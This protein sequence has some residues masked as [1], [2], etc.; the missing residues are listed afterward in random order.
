M[1]LNGY[2]EYLNA[3]IN[4]VDG[5]L[6]V[7]FMGQVETRRKALT[8]AAKLKEAYCSGLWRAPRK[9]VTEVKRRVKIA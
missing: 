8:R 3:Y 5:P 1:F 6:F 4:G 7:K 2:F 9:V